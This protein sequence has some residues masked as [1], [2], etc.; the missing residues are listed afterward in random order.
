[1][2]TPLKITLV[3]ADQFWEDKEANFNNYNRLQSQINDS[4]LI[5]LP[6]MFN[7]AFSMNAYKLAENEQNSPSIYWLKNIAITKKTAIYTSL[8]FQENRK[9]YNRGVFVYPQGNIIYYDKIKT[10]GLAK[11]NEIFAN[12]TK[13]VF[14]NLNGWNIKLQICYDLRFPE[15]SL[16]TI[17]NNT[18]IYDVLIY[19]A[20]WPN[21]RRK[22]W[23]KLLPARAIENQAYVVA[24]NRV[25][26]DAK[27]HQYNGDSAVFDMYGN[28]LIELGEQQCV[29][30]ITINYKDLKTGRD[31]LPFLKDRI[32]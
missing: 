8:I 31:K 1:M 16:N 2:I 12:G 4:N 30:S 26:T 9:Y 21:Q 20:N 25:G 10:F 15:I 24:V 5:V 32:I 23:L 27:K 19:I 28:K 13:N 11:E 22:Q 7:T 14:V 3:Q 18:P 6:E 29:K 17:K